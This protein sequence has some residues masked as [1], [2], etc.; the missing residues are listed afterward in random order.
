MLPF[1]IKLSILETVIAWGLK[2]SSIPKGS[3][4]G[5]YVVSFANEIAFLHPCF[6]ASN[7]VNI[8]TSSWFVTDIIVSVSDIF[9]SF[10]ISRSKL[11]PFI[12]NV[13]FKSAVIFSLFLYLIQ[14][15]LY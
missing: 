9:A 14:L 10:R 6:F 3:S 2:T 5:L 11:L 13:S 12:T 15:I 4:I 1:L 8:F 7:E